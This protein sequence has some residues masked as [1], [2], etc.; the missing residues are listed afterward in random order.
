MPRPPL[1]MKVRDLDER[2]TI[3]VDGPE[4]LSR[5]CL[6]LAL[7]LCGQSPSFTAATSDE[8]KGTL[9]IGLGAD[10][11]EGARIRR[12]DGKVLLFMHRD[13][14][15]QLLR[16]AVIRYR[17]GRGWNESDVGPLT[18]RLSGPAW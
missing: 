4:A 10:R 1:M 15:D 3:D 8:R 18:V 6:E 2:L 5:W 17:T 7:L 11:D 12:E 16:D 13:L 9:W 14:V